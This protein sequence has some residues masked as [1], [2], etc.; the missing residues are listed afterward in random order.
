MNALSSQAAVTVEDSGYF[1]AGDAPW[2]ALGCS[3]SRPGQLDGAEL[4]RIAGHGVT[5]LRIWIDYYETGEL[6]VEALRS[7]RGW[8]ERL[9]LRLLFVLF[10]PAFLT[11]M[12]ELSS[13]FSQGLTV[14][15]QSCQRP[16]DVLS[17][18]GAFEAIAARC[19]SVLEVFG[20][21]PTLLG[22]EVVNQTDDLYEAGPA[23]MTEFI[24]R[25]AERVREEDARVGVRRPLTASS[26]QPAPPAWLL[27]LDELDF[28]GFH[29]YARSVHDPVNRVDGAVHV[30]AALRYALAASP[31]PRPVLDTESGSIGHLFD[32]ATPRPDPAFRAELAHNLRWAHFASGGAGAGLHISANDERQTPVGRRVPLSRLG[33]QPLTGELGTIEAIARMWQLAPGHGPVR[34]LANVLH[35][36]DG[37]LGFASGTGQRTIGWLLRDTRARDL[38]ADV[39]HALAAGPTH[40]HTL[41]LRLLALDA[42]SQAYQRI[43][44]D[45]HNQYSRKAVGMLLHRGPSGLR[46]AGELIDEGLEQLERFAR[47]APAV[48]DETTPTAEP[49]EVALSGLGPGHHRLRWLD[50]TT[51]EVVASAEVHGPD[52]TV[53]TPPF[54]RHLAFV[55]APGVVA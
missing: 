31:R 49:A 52:V 33:W 26:F 42:W 35:T 11:D 28:I 55:L 15:N 10:S 48:L 7:V 53:V 29:A 13:R 32:P 39:E 51:G 37:V 3:V 27:E 8:A 44:L 21:S 41:D 36:G 22:W 47:A 6:D 25:L 24:K 50:D 23:V 46:R 2:V 18:P 54:D 43:S 9:G 20:D 38:A 17:E 19:R 4:E 12:Y 14:F 34:N 30:G 40:I 5:A 1:T 16:E 45:P